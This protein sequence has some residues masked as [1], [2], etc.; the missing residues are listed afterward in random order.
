M[1]YA[2]IGCLAIIGFIIGFLGFKL[3]QKQQ[4]DKAALEQYQKDIN[5]LQ[6]QLQTLEVQNL[7]ALQKS[8]KCKLE[9]ED[10]KRQRQYEE[11]R[12]EEC[13]KD[14]Q[15]ALDTYH[16][17]TDNKLKDIDASIEKQRQK[18]QA[19]LD[20]D[21]NARKRNIELELE[22]LVKECDDQAEQ[23][24][25][26]MAEI[27]QQCT[28]TSNEYYQKVA[29]A[30]ER[31]ESIERTLAQYEKDKQAKLF[32]TIQ[33]PDEY[34]D[35]IEFLLTTVAAKV[36]HPDIISKLVWQEYVK[37]NLDDTFKRIEIKAE[38][39]IYKITNID[40]G[41]C[42]IGKSTNV[43]TRI[44]DH[45]KSSVGI[46]SIADQAVHHAILKEGFWNW[47]I[48]V[49]TYCDKEQLSELEKYYITFFKSMEHG[50]NKIL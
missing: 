38:P 48:E 50:Y 49:I 2:L 17:L 33:L 32:Y 21:F 13:K 16:D 42:Y 39:G 28:D 25:S 24:K 1:I 9:Y 44:A 43:K 29:D 14:I 19:D 8:A 35:D 7:A 10:Y 31:F 15:T 41:K 46:R 18:R 12:L 20:S 45:F 30:Q 23:A 27:I 34:K 22:S 6:E 40:T 26:I 4:V 37:P 36:Q 5:D 47:A 3:F 11:D